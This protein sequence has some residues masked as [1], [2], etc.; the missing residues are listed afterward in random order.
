MFGPKT[1]E[2][3]YNYKKKSNIPRLSMFKNL[4]ELFY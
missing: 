4:T 2:I 1:S 3:F